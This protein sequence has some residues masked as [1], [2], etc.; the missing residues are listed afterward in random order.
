MVKLYNDLI[1]N[2]AQQNKFDITEI[3]NNIPGLEKVT[4]KLKQ[5]NWSAT[6]N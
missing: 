6:F 2:D 4:L 3:L 1:L 5:H